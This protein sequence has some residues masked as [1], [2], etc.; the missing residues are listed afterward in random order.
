MADQFEDFRAFLPKYLSTADQQDL[1][2]EL[3]QFPPNIDKR[4]Y[5]DR[6][7]GE[8]VIFQGDGLTDLPVTNLP[9]PRI[10]NARHVMVMS[11]ANFQ[12]IISSTCDGKR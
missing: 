7:R 12:S 10:G 4:L 9:N 2:A 8:P 3:S 6:L 5:T 11:A 1:F